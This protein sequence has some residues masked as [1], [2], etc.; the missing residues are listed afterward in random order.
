MSNRCGRGDGLWYCLARARGRRRRKRIMGIIQTVFSVY[1]FNAQLSKPTTTCLDPCRAL[2]LEQTSTD[3]C[4]PIRPRRGSS[5]AAIRT[6]T[7]KACRPASPRFDT[8]SL[9]IPASYPNIVRSPTG[10][11]RLCPRPRRLRLRLQKIGLRYPARCS[12]QATRTP[13]PS[14]RYQ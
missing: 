11:A 14:Q 6:K 10:M 12:N 1:P 13:P 4:P 7:T 8:Y 2:T 9:A 5:A 3:N